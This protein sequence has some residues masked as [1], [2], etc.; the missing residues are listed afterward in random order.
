[1]YGL[2]AVLAGLMIMH[3]TLRPDPMI[4]GGREIAARLAER[5]VHSFVYAYHKHTD[6][7]SLNPQLAWYTDGWMTGWREGYSYTPVAFD[8]PRANDAQ[9]LQALAQ[10][11]RAIVY[12]APGIPVQEELTFG[13]M[14]T[15]A[16]RSD[17]YSLYVR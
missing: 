7:D 2:A 14:Y 11:A 12:Y 17:H 16:F 15:L 1:V 6:A 10:N 13:G 4:T 3:V 8:A 5:G 9:L